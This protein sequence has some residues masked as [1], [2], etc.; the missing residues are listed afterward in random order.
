MDQASEILDTAGEVPGSE[1]ELLDLAK[2][3]DLRRLKEKAR[4]VR[5]EAIK[6]EELNQRQ[7]KA[8]S[9]RAWRDE[10]GMIAFAGTLPPETAMPFIT[11]LE[12]ETDR[13]KRAAKEAGA[14]IESGT[15]RRPMRSRR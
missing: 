14:E 10:L 2:E 4:D 7:H 13:L 11:R 6:P 9:F 3:G 15:L 1:K 12:R 8:R 5:L